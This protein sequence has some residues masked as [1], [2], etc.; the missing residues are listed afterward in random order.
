MTDPVEPNSAPEVDEFA[1]LRQSVASPEKTKV[2]EEK[3]SGPGLVERLSTSVSEMDP[4]LVVGVGITALGLV[5]IV[6]LVVLFNLARSR[7]SSSPGTQVVVVT[8]NP[9]PP[10]LAAS[11]TPSLTAIPFGT[12]TP[13]PSSTVDLTGTVT[14]LPLLR[15]ATMSE[16]KG[17]VQIRTDANAP[18]TTVKETL[19]IVPGTTVL[20]GESSS[21]KIELSEGSVIRLSS[22]T[23]FTLSEMS[24][25][26]SRPNTVLGLDFG[27]LWAI[28][29]KVG[30]G[31]F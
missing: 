29:G 3:P 8:G 31:T 15:F 22:Q 1:A 11:L 23:Q 6:G 14:N 25:T 13:G 12:Q 2:K 7:P 18:W 26:A 5:T 30:E 9:T 28:V 17:S 16:I 24:G 27:K 4:R 21:V 20:T 19:T 10:P